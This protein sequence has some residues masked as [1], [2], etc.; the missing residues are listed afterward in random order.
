[1][2]K[3]GGFCFHRKNLVDFKFNNLFSGFVSF[4]VHKDTFDDKLSS[5]FSEFKAFVIFNLKLGKGFADALVENLNDL[6]EVDDNLL[7]LI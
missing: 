7:V 6:W 5:Y 2:E 3:D 4:K 1:M